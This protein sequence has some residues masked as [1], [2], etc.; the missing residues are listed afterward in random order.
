MRLCWQRLRWSEVT[1]ARA[2]HFE[3]DLLHHDFGISNFL[4]SLHRNFS[5]PGGR[6]VESGDE[7]PN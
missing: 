5:P 3:G 4:R 2:T 6:G 1:V 7:P